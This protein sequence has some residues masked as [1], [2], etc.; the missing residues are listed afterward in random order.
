V[1]AS[2]RKSGVLER[3]ER[4]GRSAENFFL[5]VLLAGMLLLGGSQILL[6]NFLGG[7]LAWADE[8]LRIM[9]LWLAM[10]GAVAASRDDRH[11]SIDV[12]A[13]VLSVRA[14]AGLGALISLITACVCLVLAWYGW[15]FVSESR[16]FEDRLLGSLPAWWFQSVVPAAFLLMGY[17]YLVWTMRRLRILLR[18]EPAA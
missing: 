12:L 17:R 14:R 5:A 3:A 11:I 9:V 1:T 16:E 10:A 18:G 7:G 13:R 2:D 4:L 15:S 8:A 6:R